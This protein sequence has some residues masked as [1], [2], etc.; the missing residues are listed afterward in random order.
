MREIKFRAWNGVEMSEPFDLNKGDPDT[1]PLGL[2]HMQYTGLEDKNG[3]PVYEGD[4]VRGR[5]ITGGKTHYG[6]NV[7]EY[8]ENE[9]DY[10]GYCIGFEINGFFLDYEVIGNIYEN[11]DLLK[12]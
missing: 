5:I 9:Y 7:V 11:P 4:I 8:S 2:P 6:T 12:D 3:N 10:G 1:F